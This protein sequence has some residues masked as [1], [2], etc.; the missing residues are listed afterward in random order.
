MG[1]LSIDY[2][3]NIFRNNPQKLAS[4]KELLLKDFKAMES[5][6]FAHAGATD[7]S[8]M[9]SELHKIKPIV[10]N[11]GFSRMLDLIEK[12]HEKRDFG[13]D[14]INQLNQQLKH[15]LNDIYTFLETQ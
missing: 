15:C 7:L 10:F 5:K 3:L 2:Y 8:L 4:M 1:D 14:Q 9:R 12:Y 13:V 6:L 11:L